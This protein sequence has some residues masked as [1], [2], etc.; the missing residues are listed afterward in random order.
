MKESLTILQEEV[1]D[2]TKTRR[3]KHDEWSNIDI[4]RFLKKAAQGDSKHK[5]LHSET[6]EAND[7]YKAIDERAYR[8]KHELKSNGW[9]HHNLDEWI[10]I[11]HSAARVEGQ[12][13]Q[14]LALMYSESAL[15]YSELLDDHKKV[16]S[17]LTAK[18]IELSY[19]YNDFEKVDDEL[20]Q[21]SQLLEDADYQSRMY[22]EQLEHTQKGMRTLERRLRREREE[23][24]AHR[25]HI[26][27]AANATTAEIV[28]GSSSGRGGGAAAGHAS[29][30]CRGGHGARR[31][32]AGASGRGGH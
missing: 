9:K 19:T 29:R 8:T 16:Q 11:C 15:M 31:G 4:N 17:E 22:R 27:A 1:I 13:A 14:E 3:L 7:I 28:A 5:I 26:Q 24:A 20:G 10:D 32:G 2:A 25:A 30:R 12:S 23:F 18:G 21:V 6:P